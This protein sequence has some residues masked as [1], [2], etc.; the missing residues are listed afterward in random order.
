MQDVGAALEE[1]TIEDSAMTV[2]ERM[3]S[4]SGVPRSASSIGMVISSSTSAVDMP[5]PS[6][7]ISTSGGANSGKT[8]TGIV[9]QQLDAETTISAA[10]AAATRNRNFRLDPMIQRNMW[11]S[12][13]ALG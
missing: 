5:M 10:A 1:E 12:L 6:V 11:T 3:T 13:Q 8:S 2:V 4:S 7:W 9:A